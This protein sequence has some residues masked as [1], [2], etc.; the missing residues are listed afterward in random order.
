MFYVSVYVLCICE[1]VVH[2]FWSYIFYESIHYSYVLLPKYC[3]I[4]HSQS[5]CIWCILGLHGLFI[6][7]YACLW[8]FGLIFVHISLFELSLTLPRYH[9][10]IYVFI[11][12]AACLFLCLFA[13]NPWYSS[14]TFK[15]CTYIYVFDWCSTLLYFWSCICLYTWSVFYSII[16]R[17]T[18]MYV[19]NNLCLE[20]SFLVLY[21]H[22]WSVCLCV[23]PTVS[24]CML[25]ICY[26]FWFHVYIRIVYD[27]C[28]SLC[29]VSRSYCSVVKQY[30]CL[31]INFVKESYVSQIWLSYSN[32]VVLF[33]I[34][35][36]I[37]C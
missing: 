22:I 14:A 31:H 27:Q 8:L 2:M 21:I 23:L 7:S 24:G 33:L 16:F 35:A 12:T 17:G 29:N 28:T 5:T 15:N 37:Y 26:Y 1:Y 13:I 36:F 6:P 3:M 30:A 4:I 34:M 11:R 19:P 18:D 9:L 20:L 10:C 32:N 25:S